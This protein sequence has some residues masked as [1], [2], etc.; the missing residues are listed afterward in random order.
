MAAVTS[1]VVGIASAGFSAVQGFS[2]AAK[3]KTAAEAADK[4][5]AKAMSEAKAK[6]QVDMYAGLNV[7]LDAYEAEFENQIAGQK[8]AIEALQEGDSRALAAGV[9][10]VG[11]AQTQAGE[12]TRIAMGEEISDLNKMKADSKDA[13]NQ[14]LITMDVSA[15]KE[16]NM[17]KRDAEAARAQG[18]SQGVAGI[19]GVA[20]GIGS[21][22]PLY[23]Q[24]A[25]DRRGSKLAKQ[26]ANQKPEG[27]TDAQYAANIGAQGLSRKDYKSL[28]EGRGRFNFKDKTLDNQT[29]AGFDYNNQG[30]GGMDGDEST[31]F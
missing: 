1:A 14:Q 4:A 5:A 15:A 13:I 24:S 25:A 8:Q 19:A 6:A 20:G 23:G 2:S 18:I 21:L 7:P 16:Q 3:A 17:R 28:S 31:W 9:G 10:R 27:M 22:A 11:A 30:P 29:Q 12:Q 26:Y